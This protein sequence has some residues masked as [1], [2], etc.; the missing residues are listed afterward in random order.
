MHPASRY[1]LTRQAK[2]K[3]IATL[4]VRACCILQITTA[5]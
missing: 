2:Q 1:A 4:L 5:L 3:P